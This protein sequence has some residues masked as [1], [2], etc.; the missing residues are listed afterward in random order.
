MKFYGYVQNIWKYIAIPVFK[1][2]HTLYISAVIDIKRPTIDSFID[3]GLFADVKRPGIIQFKSSYSDIEF[4]E[5]SPAIY[6]FKNAE[7]QLIIGSRYYLTYLYQN[8][9][10]N[11]FFKGVPIEISNLL[12]V[13]YEG[14]G[15]Y[16]A[17]ISGMN[18]YEARNFDVRY[19]N[20]EIPEIK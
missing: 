11:T 16:I 2:E 14:Y 6:I 7:G 20:G 10:L 12:D 15:T 18:F 5:G 4:K 1:D 17:V 8:G 9:T 19:V 13:Y 3:T